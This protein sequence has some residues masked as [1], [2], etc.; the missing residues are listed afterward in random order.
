MTEPS[1][2][3]ET[4]AAYDTVAVDYAR[5]IPDVVEGPLDRGMLAAFAE[6]PDLTV[7]DR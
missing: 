6:R 2:L 3:T 4:R 1:W 7:E 5:L